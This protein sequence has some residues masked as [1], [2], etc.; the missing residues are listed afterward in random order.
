MKDGHEILENFDLAERNDSLSFLVTCY[1]TFDCS[2]V[3]DH[4]GL[5]TDAKVQYLRTKSQL[6]TVF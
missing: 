6:L 3:F 1:S 5:R 2:H 4:N